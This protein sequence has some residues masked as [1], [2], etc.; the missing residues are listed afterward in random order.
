MWGR[1]MRQIVG[2]GATWRLSL[3]ALT[4]LTGAFLMACGD[5]SS[6]A[7]APAAA[8]P[9]AAQV[10]ATIAVFQFQPSPLE[11]KAGATV[12]W[13]NGDEIE[14]TVTSGTPESPLERF[15]LRL[16]GKGMTASF[17]FSEPGTYPYYCARHESMRGEVRV[18]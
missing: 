7:Q 1:T 11:V 14:H 8:T 12:T 16:P 13:T 15:N 17:T 2:L 10:P 5:D 9:Q 3:V 4:G 18:N 6:A